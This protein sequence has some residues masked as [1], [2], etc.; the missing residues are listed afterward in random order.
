MKIR[1]ILI[2]IALLENSLFAGIVAR[3]NNKEITS[4]EFKI[5][6]YE[7]YKLYKQHPEQFPQISIYEWKKDLRKYTLN[8][9]IKNKLFQKYAEDH[10]IKVSN[11]EAER[12]FC[13]TFADNP[14][15]I[16]NGKFSRKKFIKFKSENTDKYLEILG[17]I[18]RDLLHFKIEQI[19]KNQFTITDQQLFNLYIKQNA[20]IKLNYA[21]IPDSLM[22]V[23]F[24]PDIDQAKQYYYSHKDQFYSPKKVKIRLLFIKDDEFL[25]QIKISDDELRNYYLSLNIEKDYFAIKDSLENCL[26]Y[27][28]AHKEAK[29]Y[30]KQVLSYL[31]EKSFGYEKHKKNEVLTKY[32][33]YE[34]EYIPEGEKINQISKSEEIIRQALELN[35]QEYCKEPFELPDRFV[36]FQTMDI[37]PAQPQ[38]LIE[39]GKDVWKAYLM[40]SESEA[41]SYFIHHISKELSDSLTYQCT[42][43]VLDYVYFNIND[44]EIDV[45]LSEE[46]LIDYYNNNPDKF[47]IN[48]NFQKIDFTT[49]AQKHKERVAPF[50]QV[51]NDIIQCLTFAQKQKFAEDICQ[52]IANEMK[53][54]TP[55]FLGENFNVKKNEEIIN[56]QTDI[57]Q[58]DSD[59]CL[60]VNTLLKQE[61]FSNDADIG[62]IKKP[63]LY[64]IY[65]IH[66]RIENYQA[67]FS[68]VKSDIITFIKA[69][70]NKKLESEYRNYYEKNKEKF[71]SKDSIKCAIIFVPQDLNNITI[72]DSTIERFYDEHREEF[73]QPKQALF[74]TIFIS[75]YRKFSKM[76]DSKKIANKVAR[77]AKNGV[78]FNDLAMLFSNRIVKKENELKYKT[79]ADLSDELKNA[80]YTMKKSISEPIENSDGF[81]IIKLIDI[82]DA[83]ILPFSE[84][85]QR[86]RQQLTEARSDE[87]A[88]E[89][90]SKIDSKVNV[91]NDSLA[92]LYADFFFKIDWICL[93][94]DAFQDS[95]LG[96]ISSLVNYESELSKLKKGQKL[97]AIIK[98]DTGYFI[99]FLLDRKKGR[100]LTYDEV[101]A[102]VKK[103]YN[104]LT[105][106]ERNKE[107]S[108]QIISRIK[109]G[110]NPDSL[111]T[112][113]S[114]WHFTDWLKLND[115]I[116]GFRKEESRIILEDAINR[117]KGSFSHLLR[118][119]NQGFA[120]YQV[121]DVNT[122]SM[123]K[124]EIEKEKFRNLYI[125]QKY[126]QWYEKYKG[127]ANIEI[128]IES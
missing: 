10:N 62:I 127:M 51:R 106:I 45:D 61:I 8:Q 32:E 116:P 111:L 73:F 9:L 23:N 83:R 13:Q 67:K 90:I 7:N 103:E 31:S 118:L 75:K 99:V 26:K 11:A 104:E 82:R 50:E 37:I 95:I 39:A 59:I 115:N 34:L 88:L 86:I 101:Y 120:F 126:Q 108:Q 66:S 77:L 84:V 72:S 28:L 117:K 43:I 5:H 12:Y 110:E 38:N 64:I 58:M 27:Q 21:I 91:Y 46:D 121:E 100:Q 1:T 24:S 68:D 119:K 123:E 47:T 93:D 56:F 124:F 53:F 30:A 49:K 18:K 63:P 16:E 102:R 36:I 15:F 98:S 35:I 2:I 109:Q 17:K 125:K 79:I 112:Y 114:G 96:K 57:H 4:K 81:Y 92:E 87:L 78:D 25:P 113:F 55:E 52:E 70:N 107:L 122:I 33:M 80:I 97:S 14:N 105:Q 94:K 69:E 48:Q 128:C 40:D 42:K 19:I 6:F 41:K 20:K 60:S 89:K 22:P 44:M 71:V 29:K 85:K 65:K 76:G 3:V 54:S 74:Q